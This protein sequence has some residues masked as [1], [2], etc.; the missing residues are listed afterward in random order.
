M[1][2]FNR[3]PGRVVDAD[4]RSRNLIDMKATDKTKSWYL[5]STVNEISAAQIDVDNMNELAPQTIQKQQD[6]QHQDRG[7]VPDAHKLLRNIRDSR[8]IYRTE[9]S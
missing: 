9:N 5:V 4:K 8:N 7:H 2:R 1:L 6:Q 3:D